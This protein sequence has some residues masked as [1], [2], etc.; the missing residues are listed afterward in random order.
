MPW[1]KRRFF[2]NAENTWSKNISPTW[3]H[4]CLGQDER[5]FLKKKQKN[6]KHITLTEVSQKE[7]Q[8]RS[9][10][11]NFRLVS[12]RRCSLFSHILNNCTNLGRCVDEP[13]T[14]KTSYCWVEH[15]WPASWETQTLFALIFRQL[16]QLTPAFGFTISDYLL[17]ILQRCH[18]S[19]K[20]SNPSLSRETLEWRPLC[21]IAANVRKIW[22]M[23]D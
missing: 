14:L 4:F 16:Y 3:F 21:T 13:G 22:Q 11:N 9:N 19:F 8:Q 17:S 12:Q 20:L 1:Q 7:C 5:S 2:I 15:P 10:C 23:T 18:A 6:D